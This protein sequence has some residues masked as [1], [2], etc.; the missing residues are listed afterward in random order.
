L[1]E[2]PTT[3]ETKNVTKV[4]KKVTPEKVVVEEVVEEP[5]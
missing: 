3:V 2:E 1:K 5:A 4:I